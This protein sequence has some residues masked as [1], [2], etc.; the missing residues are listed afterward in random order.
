MIL[1]HPQHEEEE[2]GEMTYC[3]ICK[4]RVLFS[5][6]LDGTAYLYSNGGKLPK[7]LTYGIGPIG[8]YYQPGFLLG[9]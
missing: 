6:L 5:G 7:Y 4:V 9:T 2:E 8:Q 1:V 3:V